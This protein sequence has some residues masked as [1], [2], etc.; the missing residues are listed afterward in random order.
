MKKTRIFIA[1][2]FFT[3]GLLF[4]IFSGIRSPLFFPHQEVLPLETPSYG[5]VVKGF[6][7][8]QEFRMQKEILNGLE[9]AMHTSTIRKRNNNIMILLDSSFRVIYSEPFTN[10]GLQS[11]T[12]RY[13]PFPE[14][15]KVGKGQKVYLCFASR[16]GEPGNSLMLI[17]NPEEKNLPEIYA[18]E[19]V[20]GDAVAAMK[21]ETPS[22]PAPG[23]LVFK[24]Y[25][26]NVN[27]A[28]WFKV[29]LILLLAGFCLLIYRWLSVTHWL[30]KHPFPPEWAFAFIG[31]VY[32]LLFIFISPPLQTPDETLHFYRSYQIAEGNLFAY[33]NT[34]PSALVDVTDAFYPVYFNPFVKLTREEIRETCHAPVLKTDRITVDTPPYLF[35]Y[36][37]QSLGM[38]LAGIFGASLLWDI[39]LGSLLNL[40]VSLFLVWMAIRIIPTGKWLL[41]LLGLMPMTMNQFA[42]L[43][44]DALTIALSFLLFAIFLDGLSK[45]GGVLPKSWWWR[46]ILVA[47]LLALC[48][49]PYLLISLL[50]LLIS[51]GQ[52]GGIKR[53]LI[54]LSVLFVVLV[55]A[56]RI[57]VLRDAMKPA[58]NRQTASL[59]FSGENQIAK[60]TIGRGLTE[61]ENLI[62]KDSIASKQKTDNQQN[63][64]A[65]DAEKTFNPAKPNQGV[66]PEAQTKY[67]LSNPSAFLDAVIRSIKSFG[68]FYLE[69]FIGKLGWLVSSLPGW[70]IPL[71]LIFLLISVLV[72]PD[73]FVPGWKARL[74]FAGIFI[75]SFFAIELVMY[76]GWTPVE[77]KWVEGI[78][79]RYFIPVAP[80]AFLLLANTYIGRKLDAAFS[81][82]ISPCLPWVYMFVVLLSAFATIYTLLHRFY[83]L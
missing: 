15:L 31:L 18:K 20:Q 48:K 11:A 8:V 47:G 78:Q 29:L 70:V 28:V 83:F 35:P 52:A 3:I 68:S 64:E 16:D 82:P 69:T 21:A 61:G 67:V 50:V 17:R 62:G 13:F 38:G 9:V 37:P 55:G 46:M 77:A 36:I 44:Y 65:A 5:K 40:L 2:G 63:E 81:V 6:V 12:S 80:L 71:Y 72:N 54:Y 26:S 57:W 1:V 41:F 49:P 7:F 56:N 30:M 42:S 10:S 53:Y 43:S 32:G 79:G 73:G 75:V 23:N 39:Y 51:P 33:D 76:I 27:D 59:G 22:Y 4:I 14:G 60:G 45:R 34:V 74:F 66:N 58:V 24:T 19:L 25:E